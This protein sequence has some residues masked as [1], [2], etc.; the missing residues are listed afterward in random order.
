M[1]SRRLHRHRCHPRRLPAQSTTLAD[2]VIFLASFFGIAESEE[3]QWIR[4][5]PGQATIALTYGTAGALIIVFV[6]VYYSAQIFFLGAEFAKAYGDQ[7]PVAAEKRPA[8]AVSEY[9]PAVSPLSY[10]KPLPE[11]IN[12][13]ENQASAS[14]NYPQAT[15]LAA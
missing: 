3:R 10:R 2:C 15:P 14:A 1:P 8:I 6:S 5:E 9:T 4:T 7:R 12:P 13:T 11:V